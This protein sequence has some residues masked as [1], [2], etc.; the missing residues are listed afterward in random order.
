ML[1]SKC[2]GVWTQARPQYEEC[3]IPTC[4]IMFEGSV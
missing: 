3:K 4:H 1:V 2:A